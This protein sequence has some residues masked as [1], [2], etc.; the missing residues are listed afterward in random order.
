MA[1]SSPAR[2]ETSDIAIVGIALRFPGAHGPKAFW[3]NLRAGVESVQRFGDDELAARGVPRS[4]L[5]DPAYVKAG[6]V[7]EGMDRF[8]AEFFGFSPKDAAILDPQH[9][10]FLECAWEALEDAGHPPSSFRGPIGVFGG[11]GMGSYFAFHL[12]TNPALVE[13]TGLFLLRHTG[14]DKDFLT[15]RVS[16]CLDLEGPSVSIQ[17]ACST[18]LV[19]VHA[20]CQS[21]NSGEC[22]LALAG[23]VTIEL[24]HGVGYLHRAGEILSPD[25]HCRPFDHRAQ[26]TLFGSGVGIV[27]LRPLEDALR[28][29]DR[30]YALI[31]GSAVNNDGA[32][33]VSYLAPSVDGQA[34]VV[35]EALA[36]AGVEADTLEYIEAH[37]SGTPLGDS[38][39]VAA[40]MQAFGRRSLQGRP[41]CGL[42]SV[43]ANI[44][45]L[46]TA[47]GV[48]G[49]IKTALAL[50]HG[51]IPPT[52][53]F[54]APNAAIRFADTPFHVV[55]QLRPWPRGARP[56]RA[57]VTAL[58]IGGTN[59]H[60]VLE[61]PPSPVPT[62]T[63]RR[64]WQVLG[65]SARS[66]RALDA[67]SRR[68]AAHLREN[69][70]QSLADVGYTLFAGR[71]AFEQRR[72]LCSRDAAEAAAWLE[73]G[74]PQRVFSHGCDSA[75][76]SVV[77]LLPGGGAQYA[78]M[79]AGL[80]ESEPV[81]REQIDRGIEEFRR[82]TGRDL[83]SLWFSHADPHG[84][85]F[86][87]P[88]LQLP[89]I[90]I[91]EHALA[92]LWMSLG[93]RPAALL[94]HSLGENTA[95]CLAG[96]FSFEDALALVTLR[97]ELLERLPKGGMLSVPL[98]ADDV[99]PWLG[100]DL[101]LAALNAPND[102]VVSGPSAALEDL[103]QRLAA[104]GIEARRIPISIAAHSRMVEPSLP[105]FLEFLRG[106][107]LHPPSLP[108]LS[109]CSG[110]W[111]TSE[112]AVRPEYW[113][114]Q[115][116]STVRFADGVRTLLAA[117]A[118]VFLEVGPGKSL[119]SLVRQQPEAAG[120]RGV[121]A[122]LRHPEE[123]VSDVAHFLTAFGRLWA[124]GVP[125]DTEFLWHG[126]RRAR[127]SLPTYPFQ[128]QRYWIEPGRAAEPPEA[129]STEPRP[130]DLL[131]EGFHRPVWKE[132]P[133]GPEPARAPART[134]LLFLD[135]AGLGELLAQRLRAR[136]DKVVTVRESDDNRRL[137]EGEY[138]L[139][140]ER[141]R[142][143]YVDL[144]RDLVA[145]GAMPQRIV[146]LWMLTPDESFRP[147]SNFFHRNQ[148]RGFYSLFFLAQALAEDGPVLPQAGPLHITVVG[149]GM[150]ALDG[151]RLLHPEKAT[152]QGPCRVMP[153][154]FP[155][156]TCSSV[157]LP[158]AVSGA[159]ATRR[160]VRAA[161]LN[162]LLDLVEGEVLSAPRCAA[163]AYRK[164]Q[165]YEQEFE[166]VAL[167]PAGSNGHG[168][169]RKR[170]VYLVTGGLG[171]LGLVV[172]AHL[173]RQAR[174]RIVLVGRSPMPER[175]EWDDW[176]ERHGSDDPTARRIRA[177]REIES[178]GS[179]V[180][181]A[182][183]DVTDVEAM[184][185]VLEET[186]RRFGTLH[187]VF[188]AAG[189]LRDA[190]ILAKTQLDVEGVFG[191]KVHGTLVLDALLA[192][193]DLDFLVLFSSV[194][195]LVAPAGQVDYV[196]ASAFLD[197]YA[198][199]AEKPNI[200][201]IV[202]VNWGIWG[203]VGMAANALGAAAARAQ[204][205]LAGRTP[206]HPLFDS[207]DG[208]PDAPLALQARYGSK[209]HWLLEEHRTR[210]GRAVVP[211]SAYL[212]LARA[213]LVEAGESPV[214][215]IHDL[216]FLRPLQIG[217]G[218]SRRVQVEL[219]PD[220][221]GHGFSVRSR[222][223]DPGAVFETHAEARLLRRPPVSPPEVPLA[224]IEARCVLRRAARG[225][226]ALR[227]RQDELMRF[228]PRW[229]NL[230]EVRV[231]ADEVLATLELPPDFVGDLEEYGL[232]PA[233]LDIATS[234]GLE[235]LDSPSV[236]PPGSKGA[237]RSKRPGKAASNPKRLWVPLSYK[238][239]RIHAPL[240]SR[241]RSWVKSRATNRSDGEVLLFDVVVL[242]ERGRVCLE[243]EEFA[244]R[245]VTREFELAPAAER[246]GPA[247]ATGGR[248]PGA[249]APAT[250]PFLP[251]SPG[252]SALH[253]N[254]E[255]GI[256]P[257]EG[258]E[259]LTRILAAPALAQVVATSIELE[260]L[261]RQAD[262]L[263][264]LPGPVPAEEGGAEIDREFAD[265]ADGIERTLAGF[266]KE[267]LGVR[268]VG[269][270]ESFFDLGGHSLIA[271]RLFA[272]IK[273]AYQVEFPISLLFEAPTI[274]R[275]AEAIRR[276]TEGG[277]RT[278]AGPVRPADPRPTHLVPMHPGQGGDRTPFF[279]VA[280]MFGNVLNLRHLAHLL[281][282]ERR[283][284][285]LQALGLYGVHRPHETFEAMARDYLIE[286]R[287]AQPKGPYLLGG[288]S[289]GGITAYEMAQQLRAAG[290]EVA[291][292]AMLDTALPYSP[293]LSTSDRAR[294][295]WQR[296]RRR[297]P[298]AVT[299]WA[300]DKLRFEI[301]RIRKRRRD[302]TARPQPSEFRSEEI[303]AAFRRALERYTVRPF[304]GV[305]T[306]FRPKLEVAHVLGEG[307]M[308]NAQREFV[309]PDNGW[310]RYVARLDVY[311]VPG[312]HD[313]MVL[314]PNVRVLANKLQKCIRA[315]EPGARR[316]EPEEASHVEVA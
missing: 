250:A 5:A 116:R 251:G 217:D 316:R 35:A 62:S 228:G 176:L 193:V 43:K 169:L 129:K 88:S 128:H 61:E 157:D 271:V 309:F 272:R 180:L 184:R 82:H 84:V 192:D 281:G 78:Q 214:F 294:I 215:E 167:D 165:R 239:V 65:L 211:G 305:V 273:K 168:P 198:R 299:E 53:N 275:C 20:A 104:R 278:Q 237:R 38:I 267:L 89:A 28:D 300:R 150:Q 108:F 1:S 312:N 138:A 24:P 148:E 105:R 52:P 274:E 288:F 49:L 301:A 166:H 284:Y 97:G 145:T 122:S 87:R 68:L 47:A 266:W 137:A 41:P 178:A 90:F 161:R 247:G 236:E 218:E 7:L 280:G 302:E 74:D 265:S 189:M 14:N 50:Q 29:G 135:A 127:V 186:R 124:C 197:A 194:S 188:H 9:R 210:T 233:L 223:E 295:L 277:T 152:I 263:G 45:H 139:A 244:M 51:E 67:A 276:A 289:G 23:G 25:G 229:R 80:H 153:R 59:A 282:N 258:M 249:E 232:H 304:P 131:S 257:A 262:S 40:L 70:G 261:L 149:N 75:P 58:G 256:P 268:R 99:S 163:V 196:A 79:G 185:G 190:P 179:E 73:S 172:A 71:R 307:R 57:G 10:Q 238:T 154:E 64:E 246:A 227:C 313:S 259:A 314:E 175:P 287:R 111:I 98:S 118:R 207:R 159:R 120:V 18:S 42:G 226:D 285:G 92:Q 243:I 297:G 254:F 44:G 126:E 308:T 298:T 91:L 121:I 55:A 191:P 147:G 3:E 160:P 143:G 296:V 113:A 132:R 110:T 34:A 31:K 253:R 112:Q 2:L 26:G 32:G 242:D 119:S 283:F 240:T 16:Y 260:G 86:E 216:L 15:T 93:V 95:A 182:R 203:E 199:S 133:R 173:A 117:P 205:S 204:T 292:L 234:C 213:A 209:T 170:G 66:K 291:L 141:G 136:G 12:L 6:F 219:R 107:R 114:E 221:L 109:N 94:G 101:D 4:L 195:A 134:W 60:V 123:K 106:I 30:I 279:L 77:F 171:G 200:R 125:V 103:V 286:L 17:T 181:L 248:A 225:T 81:F 27:A 306:L 96:V 22:D 222:S 156:L 100:P 187:G 303:G 36:A 102:S 264:A 230:R 212:E 56:R 290:E 33:K 115:L 48:A 255:H 54:E 310:G 155:G 8:D 269:L 85:G 158:L 144:V 252:R 13:S 311:E 220:A 69:P 174:A 245:S 76:A 177:V 315:V 206:R 231:G 21:L 201:R 164:D 293:V 235:L 151:E 72:V 83:R 146:H 130:I 19:A 39:E 208:D 37:G 224:Q 241:L 46:D 11:C 142:E 140:P 162:V 183:A 202:S 270:R 63:P